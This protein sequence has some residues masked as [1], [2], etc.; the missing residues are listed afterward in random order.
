MFYMVSALDEPNGDAKPIMWTNHRL[1]DDEWGTLCADFEEA[2]W[3]WLV[4]TAQL[5]VS[6]GSREGGRAEGTE[7]ESAQAGNRTYPVS[8]FAWFRKL[9]ADWRTTHTPPP[10]DRVQRYAAGIRGPYG[11][12]W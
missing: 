7:E 8:D 11:S 6:P 5:R 12:S 9:C 10:A 4:L 2:G 1:T 3:P